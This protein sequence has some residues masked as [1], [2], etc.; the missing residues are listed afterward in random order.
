MLETSSNS[1]INDVTITVCD[2][3]TASRRRWSRERGLSLW[4]TYSVTVGEKFTAEVDFVHPQVREYTMDRLRNRVPIHFGTR[5][6][7]GQFQT[8]QKAAAQGANRTLVGS[9]ESKELDV[10]DVMSVLNTVVMPR[11]REQQH[12][13]VS[14]TVGAAEDSRP[15]QQP[16]GLKREALGGVRNY[17]KKTWAG[18]EPAGSG[19]GEGEDGP[20]P[21]AENGTTTD[22][23]EDMSRPPQKEIGKE[24]FLNFLPRDD[25]RPPLKV[26]I[27]WKIDF[28]E[29]KK[30]MDTLPP[31]TYTKLI[32]KKT[33]TA[34]RKIIPRN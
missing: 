33:V 17:L 29:G 12:G 15:R 16:L 14:A 3:S 7:G 10:V 34:L 28:S 23:M 26:F 30:R 4:C 13:I 32:L 31:D 2:L 20:R 18:K 27:T 24:K 21:T 11:T 1:T 25:Q 9:S 5:Q 8:Y 19:S 6:K 22:T